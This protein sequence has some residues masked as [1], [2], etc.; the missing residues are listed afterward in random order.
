MVADCGRMSYEI[1]KLH[2][3]AVRGLAIV[4]PAEPPCPKKGE[5]WLDTDEPGTAGDSVFAHKT[6]TADYTLLTTDVHLYCDAS[7]GAFK[8][9]LPPVAANA[10]R[11]YHVQKIDGTANVV[12]LAGDG[13]ET[14]NGSNEVP[15]S[16]P[17]TSLSIQSRSVDWR[18]F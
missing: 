5:M 2:H 16:I 11:V 14:I 12:T 3:Q 8:V 7:G 15:I 10:G 4:S 6:I 9:T 18:I 17:D 13:S 1:E